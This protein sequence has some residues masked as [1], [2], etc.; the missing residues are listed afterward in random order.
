[1]GNDNE[2]IRYNTEFNAKISSKTKIEPAGIV[3]VEPSLE[4]EGVIAQDGTFVL[5]ISSGKVGTFMRLRGKGFDKNDLVTLE[6]GA[7][8]INIDQQIISDK[9][10]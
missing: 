4:V 1:M 2:K 6:I 8:S 9:D 7:V 3:I 10:G 5:G